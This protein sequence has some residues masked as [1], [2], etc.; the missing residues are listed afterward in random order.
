MKLTR[1]SIPGCDR[2][3][4][5]RRPWQVFCSLDC[6]RRY[7]AIAWQVGCHILEKARAGDPEALALVGTVTN[8]KH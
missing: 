6:R 2:T 3:F 7:T 8:P 5:A 1:C 4:Q